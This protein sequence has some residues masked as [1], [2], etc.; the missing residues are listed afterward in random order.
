MASR[1]PDDYVAH[2]QEGRYVLDHIQAVALDSLGQIPDEGTFGLSV[3]DVD[4]SEVESSGY[5]FVTLAIRYIPEG[6]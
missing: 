1:L 6:E 2:L 5:V 4:T 3:A